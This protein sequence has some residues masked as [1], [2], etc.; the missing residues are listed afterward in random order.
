[1]TD[2]EAL[3]VSFGSFGV[4]CYDLDGKLRWQR[5]LGRM[6]TRYGWGEASTPVVHGGTVMVNWDHEGQSFL[7]ALDARTGRD[8][9]RSE[10]DEPSSWATPLIVEHG[11]GTQVIV[12]GTNRIRSYD[13]ATGK[14]LWECGG[15]TLNAIPSP[16]VEDGKV[17][18]VSGYRGS[19]A[20]AIPL[21]AKGDLTGSDK[22]AWR[23]DR[24]TPYVPSPLLVGGR[25][26]Y[27]QRN[28]PLLSC[29]DITTGKVLLD[30]A[31]LPQLATL[32]ASPVCAGD[33]IYI[34]DREGTTLVIRRADEV[35]VLAVNKLE[36]TT[37][38]SPAVVGKQMF[39]RGHHA[40][41][42]IEAP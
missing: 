6:E 17:Y 30:R 21:D 29:V 42:C 23:L 5:D 3:Y 18:C 24:G 35:E 36:D 34:T 15:M 41:Y 1:M 20:V 31:R 16:V 11:G 33:R 2:G 27:T 25:L 4:Y 39:L 9:W 19:A 32:Y 14:V 37:D 38:A 26:Y 12:N 22:V 28:D 13:L 40:L 7:V 8:R 10:R